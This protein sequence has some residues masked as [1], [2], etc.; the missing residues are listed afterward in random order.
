MQVQRAKKEVHIETPKTSGVPRWAWS[1][2]RSLLVS[3]PVAHGW[4]AMDRGSE[5]S[6][7]VQS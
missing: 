5:A 6:T 3:Q 1:A 7:T 4:N 2:P